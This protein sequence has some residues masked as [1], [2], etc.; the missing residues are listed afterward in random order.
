MTT[1]TKAHTPLSRAQNR[2]QHWREQLAF[3]K[4]PCNSMT[5]GS[6][7]ANIQEDKELDRELIEKAG[8][9][10][11]AYAKDLRAI[12][13]DEFRTLAQSHGYPWPLEAY[14]EV[15]KKALTGLVAAV[16]PVSEAL[17]PEL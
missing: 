9:A 14:S 17:N 3:R 2:L 15:S 6:I 5:V 8:A 1:H 13:A 11:S 4:H 16:V 7:A 12:D 10:G